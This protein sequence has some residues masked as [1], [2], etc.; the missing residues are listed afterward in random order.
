MIVNS[1]DLSAA[2]RKSFNRGVVR[3]AFRTVN[4]KLHS[5]KIHAYRSYGMVDIFLFGICQ[6]FYLADSGSDGEL[7]ILHVA[8]YLSLYLVLEGIGK[9]KSVSIKE[10]YSVKLYR[11]VR[12]RNNNA[13]IYHMLSCKIS[14]CGSRNNTDIYA[15]R[16]DAAG[17]RHKRVSKHIAGNSRIASDHN[18]RFMIF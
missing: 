15:I 17:S 7:N 6:N 18:S 1:Y 12:C 9:L 5:G 4:N 13:R 2:A 8:L 16:S 10:L 3:S 11:V 14:D